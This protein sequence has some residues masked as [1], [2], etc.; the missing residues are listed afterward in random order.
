MADFTDIQNETAQDEQAASVP[1][2]KKGGAPYL[3][4]DGETQCTIDVLGS[5][6]KKVQGARDAITRRQLKARRVKLTPETL[7]DN[8]IDIAAAAVTG[9]SGWTDGAAE[10]PFTPENAKRMLRAEHILVQVEEAIDG[11]ADFFAS[12]SGT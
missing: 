6:A 8:R 10:Y 5:D 2:F 12:S 3:A 11:H 4:P 7:R 9:W 1:I